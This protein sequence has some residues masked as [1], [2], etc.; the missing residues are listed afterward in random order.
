MERKRLVIELEEAA[1]SMLAEEARKRNITL[2]NYVRHALRLP[3]ERQGVKPDAVPI[4]PPGIEDVPE[5]YLVKGRAS[6]QV[7]IP[8]TGGQLHQVVPAPPLIKAGYESPESV[9]SG[10]LEYARSTLRGE[11]PLLLLPVQHSF[12]PPF[13]AVRIF[14]PAHQPI[15]DRQTYLA[16]T[17]QAPYTWMND[18]NQ[19]KRGYFLTGL[20]N[21]TELWEIISCEPD[22]ADRCMFVLAP[23]RLPHGLPAPDFSK[24]TNP[25]LRAEAQQH[26]ANLEQA[27]VAHTPYAIVNSAASLSEALLHSFLKTGGPRNESL[28][29]MLNRLRDEL[30]KGPSEF[31]LICYHLMQ[32]IRITHQSSQHP[33]RV[34]SNGRPP[35]PRFALTIAE[36]MVEIL[37]SLGIVN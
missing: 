18:L 37:T 2:S 9:R 29:D 1:H 24:I 30:E 5:F 31:S 7:W 4:A 36:D 16:T 12:G 13:R 14:N 19:G 6:F 11:Y 34:I 15:A 35:R 20:P 10:Q 26:W 17:S 28:F 32:T 22:P 27:V 21:A 3:L 25:T 33:A 8:G 23:V